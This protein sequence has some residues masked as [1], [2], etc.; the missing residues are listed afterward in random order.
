MVEGMEGM[1]G[2][3]MAARK[4]CGGAYTVAARRLLFCGSREVQLNLRQRYALLALYM[5]EDT[6]NS[7]RLVT[8]KFSMGW[9]NRS[10]AKKG[11]EEVEPGRRDAGT[12]G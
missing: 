8:V 2:A 3:V 1:E 5:V 4:P 11:G 9:G 6:M 7:L 10:A 12:R